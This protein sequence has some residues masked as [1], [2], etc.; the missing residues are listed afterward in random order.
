MIQRVLTI[1]ENARKETGRIK[2]AQ[3]AVSTQSTTPIAH[4]EGSRIHRLPDLTALD[5]HESNYIANKHI[6]ISI[7]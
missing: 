3:Q 2:P 4:H 5:N 7:S 6:M 1:A